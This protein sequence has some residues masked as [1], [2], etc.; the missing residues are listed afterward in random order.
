MTALLP[1]G[2]ETLE[3]FV[4]QWAVHGTNARAELRGSSRPEQ[5]Q[6]FYDAAKDVVAGALDELDRKPLAELD[7]AEK[8]LLDLLLSFA[9]VALAVEIQGPDEGKHAELRSHMPI[10]FSPADALA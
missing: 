3:P 4:A 6:A 1:P 5:R 8:R 9:H 10:T 2:F 7:T